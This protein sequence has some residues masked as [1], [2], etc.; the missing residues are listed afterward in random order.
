MDEQTARVS[1][2]SLQISTKQSIEICNFI[3]GRPLQRAK[4][5]LNDVILMKQPVP[6]KRFTAMGH[7]K[8]K[9]AAGRYPIKASKIFLGLLESVEA[10]AQFK[11]LN[12]ANLVIDTII[13]NK[14][15]NQW[16]YGRQRRRRMKSTH[17]DIVVKE[18]PEE[19]KKESAKQGKKP[20]EQPKKEQKPVEKKPE[21]KAEEKPVEKKEQPKAEPKPA[22]K[23]ASKEK[24]IDGESK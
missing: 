19:K 22:E 16:H 12:T 17:V 4:S 1:G 9:L 6:F 15:G 24:I 18:A 14:A 20:K 5:L 23:P 10:N 3:R 11:G 7:R 21:P 8:G 2:K 13:A